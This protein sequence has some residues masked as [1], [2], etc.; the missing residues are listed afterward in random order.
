MTFT[1]YILRLGSALL[2]GIVL[3]LEREKR[4]RAA[5]LR[6]TTLVAFA[7]ALAMVISEWLPTAQAA[8]GTFGGDPARLAAG[9][10]TGIGFLGAGV[11]IRQDT[12]IRGVTT[13]AVLWTACILGLAAGSGNIG[14]AWTATAVVLVI[15]MGLPFLE[16]RMENV[17]Y[18]T[19]T[20]TMSAPGVP[21]GS[22]AQVFTRHHLTI[23]TT[24]LDRDRD[25]ITV[26][27][28]ASAPKRDSLD[29]PST[30][31]NE[32][33]LLNSVTRAAWSG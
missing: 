27:V 13:A 15:L 2:I 20:V 11:I 28:H 30:V 7:S 23:L 33:R 31:T 9:V 4:G 22:I 10:L 26:G 12:L 24:S 17:G 8:A 14:L 18:V 6:T 1:D 16:R 25:T 21:M 29:L 5:G 19:V 3:G 32:L